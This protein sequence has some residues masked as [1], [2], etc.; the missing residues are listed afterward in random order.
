M[1]MPMPIELILAAHDFQ[2]PCFMSVQYDCEAAA[3][4]IVKFGHGD[5]TA[6]CDPNA[7]I[8]LCREHTRA[9]QLA[10][11]GGPLM[12]IMGATKPPDCSCGKAVTIH[13]IK[14]LRGE[15]V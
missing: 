3:M 8:P 2:C 13:C 10:C 4:F 6:H 15:I 7:Q 14:T 12:E 1:S 9:A 5:G 11:E